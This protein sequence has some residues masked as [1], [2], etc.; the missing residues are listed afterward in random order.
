MRLVETQVLQHPVQPTQAMAA[1]VVAMQ[2][3]VLAVLA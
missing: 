2:V 1:V 3:L